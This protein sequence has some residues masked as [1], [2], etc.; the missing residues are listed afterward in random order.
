MTATAGRAE[1]HPD[2]DLTLLARDVA[3]SVF[4]HFDAG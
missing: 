2:A 3:A 1:C 4:E